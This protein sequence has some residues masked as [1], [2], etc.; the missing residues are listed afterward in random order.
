MIGQTLLHYRI[1]DRLGAGGMGEVYRATDTNL[2]RDVAIKVL[3]PEVAQ[4]TERLGRFRREAQVLAALNHTNI[5]S[6]FGLEEADGQP[7]LVLELVEGEDLKQRLEKGA[8]PLDEALEIARQIAEALEEAH[9]HGIVHR[10]LKPA[11]VKLTPDGKVKVLDFG[12]AKAWGGGAG[13]STSTLDLSA[14]PT[15]A[16]TGTL[17]GVILGTAAYMSPEQAAGKAVDKRADIWSFGV[18]LFEMLTGRFLYT[19]ETASEILASVIK[20]EPDWESVPDG[21]PPAVARLL[22]RCLRKRPRERLQDI[23]DARLELEEVAGGAPEKPG[24]EAADPAAALEVERRARRWERLA[25]VAPA[26]VLG[27]LGAFFAWRDLARPPEGRPVVRFGPDAPE[28]LPLLDA[29]VAVAPDGLQVAFSGGGGDSRGIYVRSLDTREARLLPGTEGGRGQ[30]WS[31]DSSTIAFYVPSAGEVAL[32]KIALATG[33]VQTLCTFSAFLYGQGTWSPEGHILFSFGNPD[34]VQIYTV[35]ASGGD[36]RVLREPDEANGD[37]NNALP[38]LLPDG[39]RFLYTVFSESDSRSGIWLSDLDQ[40]EQSRMVL[41]GVR[42]ARY[43]STGHLLHVRNNTLLAQP[44]DADRGVVTGEPSVVASPVGT[45]SGASFIGQ[46][47]VSPGGVL[48]YVEQGETASQL[49]WFDRGGARL[50]TVGAPDQY[51]E[52]QLSPDDR[53]VAAVIADTQGN[54]DLWTLDL[55]RGVATRVTSHPGMDFDPIWSADGRELFFSS[56]RGSNGTARLHRQRLGGREPASL[57]A[58]SDVAAWSEGVSPDGKTLLYLSGTNQAIWALPLDGSGEAETLVEAGYAFDEPQVSPDGRW[59][60]YGAQET[61]QWEVYVMP[62]RRD[63]ERVRVSPAGGR[64]P[65]WRGDGRELFYL[66][67]QGELVSVEVREA[68]GHLELGLPGELFHAGVSNPVLDEY[69][70]TKGGQRFLV[71]TPVEES[72]WSL[73]V[74]LNWPELLER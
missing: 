49:T 37:R 27:G 59:L 21:C 19:G 63:G 13:S 4:D 11:N 38:E 18:V 26:L 56:D 1:T 6:I 36:L 62:F 14:S 48:A 60:A 54:Q 67:P 46:F 39:H 10:D 71:I 29:W 7:F 51:A 31:P 57:L 61:G 50:G 22:R 8:I 58:D 23:G 24:G 66:T 70:V 42:Y 20:E 45:L 32:R 30:F 52:I 25:F 3:P 9:A 64:Q 68:G 47:S 53:R 55:G 34:R 2:G 12:L 5:A 33:A 73:N 72:G 28:D 15:L 17:A 35:S 69:A 74:V 65:R 40:P 41:P 44:F 16:R 43:A